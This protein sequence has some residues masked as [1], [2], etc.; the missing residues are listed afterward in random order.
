MG[1]VLTASLTP[2]AAATIPK[3]RGDGN[4]LQKVLKKRVSP[5]EEIRKVAGGPGVA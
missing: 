2:Q 5:E 1:D 3:N 4:P